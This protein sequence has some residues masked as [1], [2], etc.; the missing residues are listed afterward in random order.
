ML[1]LYQTIAIYGFVLTY[2]SK[3]TNYLHPFII[4]AFVLTIFAYRVP[5][6]CFKAAK[7]YVEGE[8]ENSV[9]LLSSKVNFSQHC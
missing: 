5:D 1:C 9:A 2:L 6:K 4:G 8:G 3:D 7:E